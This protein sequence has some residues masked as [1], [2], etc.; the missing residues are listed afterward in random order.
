M[1]T[2]VSLL[3]IIVA[4]CAASNN[5]I[6]HETAEHGDRPVA[7]V[8]QDP[9]LLEPRAIAG[10]QEAGQKTS[11]PE[12]QP[13]AAA[14][15]QAVPEKTRGNGRSAELTKADADSRPAQV[16]REGPRVT[17]PVLNDYFETGMTPDKMSKLSAFAILND[18]KLIK[19]FVGMSRREV[20]KIMGTRRAGVLSNPY[21]EEV[22]RTRTGQ[23]YDILFYLT[24]EPARGRSITNRHMTP[25]IF[26]EDIVYAIGKYQLKKL[27]RWT[28]QTAAAPK[29]VEILIKNKLVP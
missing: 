19:I 27:K 14:T 8:Q 3:M 21:K 25:V 23:Q 24:R 29:P 13:S 20:E 12:K 2:V 18:E 9:A 28:V 17:E 5:V 26:K 15:E 11:A 10:A 1:R 16:K 4:G 22:I 7:A 6:Q